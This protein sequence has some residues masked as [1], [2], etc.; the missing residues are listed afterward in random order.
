MVLRKQ[1]NKGAW[2]SQK[3]PELVTDVWALVA[4]TG[5]AFPAWM[6][7]EKEH[8]LWP[9]LGALTVRVVLESW[10]IWVWVEPRC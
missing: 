9:W 6:G 10:N 4:W 8:S 1:L 3:S 7:E 5:S 2:S